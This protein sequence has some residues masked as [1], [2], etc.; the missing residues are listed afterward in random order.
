M[1]L[2]HETIFTFKDLSENRRKIMKIRKSVLSG[3]ELR[4]QFF[5]PA[6]FANCIQTI[7]GCNTAGRT[8][9]KILKMEATFKNR[10][11]IC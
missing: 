5:L 9:I 2:L 8:L 11:T 3:L 6:K 1:R 7:A 4:L 10:L